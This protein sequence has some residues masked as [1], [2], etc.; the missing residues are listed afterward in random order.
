MKTEIDLRPREYMLA[1]YKRRRRPLLVLIAV[2]A[3][4]SI[5]LCTALCEKHLERSAA[6]NRRLRQANALLAEEAAPLMR[7]EADIAI[8]KEKA[9]LE[10]ALRRQQ[11][12]WSDILR[13]AEAALPEGL[14]LSSF[15]AGGQG[16]LTITGRGQA[17]PQVASFSQAL[18]ALGYFSSVTVS[19][20]EREAE[21]SYRF[22]FEV[23]LMIAGGDD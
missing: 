7:L 2:I 14:Y 1:W 10:E 9:A 4:A 17:M 19:R 11:I 5:L 16:R 20:I 18:S 3:A 6:A 15:S 8:L 23:E 21:G 22:V 13:R 12:P